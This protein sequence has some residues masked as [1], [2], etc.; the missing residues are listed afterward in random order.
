M[1]GMSPADRAGGMPRGGGVGSAASGLGSGS[2]RELVYDPVVISN[3]A[4]RLRQLR[5]T[6]QANIAAA[7]QAMASLSENWEGAGSESF[8]GAFQQLMGALQ[9]DLDNINQLSGTLGATGE[10]MAD[11]D[12]NF[13]GSLTNL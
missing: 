10:A 5:S 8:A 11:T 7:Q 1:S 13:A 2:G 3:G 6:Q 12:S 9:S 4:S